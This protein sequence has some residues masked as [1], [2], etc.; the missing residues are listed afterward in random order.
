MNDKSYQIFLKWL[1]T[2][3][4]LTV[5]YRID[6]ESLVGNVEFELALE[7]LSLSVCLSDQLRV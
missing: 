7:P 4:D 3:S 6:R 5:A 2:G 1:E